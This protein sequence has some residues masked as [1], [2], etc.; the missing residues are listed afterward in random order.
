MTRCRQP[1]PGMAVV[2]V[3]T[4]LCGLSVLRE[5]RHWRSLYN[6]VQIIDFI[7]D[8]GRRPG[9]FLRAQASAK[10]KTFV[11]RVAGDMIHDCNSNN[12]PMPPS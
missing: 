10:E 2:G 11:T 5:K 8:E 7:A 1:P 9:G 3:A 12:T 6:R 4:I